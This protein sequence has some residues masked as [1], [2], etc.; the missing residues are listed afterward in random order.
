MDL[1]DEVANLDEVNEGDK[2]E[3]YK[4]ETQTHYED[5][6]ECILAKLSMENN[7][8]RAPP[9]A[10]QMANHVG[11]ANGHSPNTR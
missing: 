9:A 11:G 7:A 4:E 3:R 5:M 8:S 6:T 10:P 1:V 2:Y